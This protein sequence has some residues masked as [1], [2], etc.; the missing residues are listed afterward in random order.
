M[1][2]WLACAL[3]ALAAFPAAP[4]RAQRAED[5]T[6]AAID[7]LV[8]AGQLEEARIRLEAWLLANPPG[9]AGATPGA[10]AHALF[11]KAGLARDWAGAEDALLSVVLGYPTSPDAPGAL[12]L[13]GKGLVAVASTG[14]SAT[15][16]IRAASYLERL[17]SDYP[18][19]PLH[20]EGQLWLARAWTASARSADACNLLRETLPRAAHDIAAAIRADLESSCDTGAGRPVP[21]ADSA[22]ANPPATAARAEPPPP[23]RDTAAASGDFT[24][25][26]AALRSRES[27]A[28]LADRLTAAGFRARIVEIQG[29]GLV[30]VRVDVFTSARAADV[31]AAELRARGFDAVVVDDVTREIRAR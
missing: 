29:S 31:R 25:Q 13:L 1:R 9:R 7:S 24:V 3:A 19:N 6:L 27:A 16:A 14:T 8:G 28:Q 15:A 26:V 20:A 5:S 30:R 22:A 12:L 21:R 11:L 18:G 2:A 23:V 4:A 17:V 10:N